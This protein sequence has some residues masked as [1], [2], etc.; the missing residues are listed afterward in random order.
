MV[1]CYADIGL[2]LWRAAPILCNYLVETAADY[3]ENKYVLELGA[4]LGLCG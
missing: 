2:T 1:L 4:G 3:I